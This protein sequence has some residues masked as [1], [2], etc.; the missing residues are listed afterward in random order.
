M[1][2]PDRVSV[3]HKLRHAP[4]P[5]SSSLVLDV[6]VLSHRHRRAAAKLEEDVVIYDYRAGTKAALPPFMLD[7]MAVTF[8][9][10]EAERA[11]ARARI[12]ELLSRVE[13]LEKETWDREGAVEDLGSA[14]A[15]K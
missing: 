15:K 4:S 6:V 13:G 1:T 5:R 8:R 11:R 9:R 12:W 14:G 10:Q 7:T 3:Y 2:Y